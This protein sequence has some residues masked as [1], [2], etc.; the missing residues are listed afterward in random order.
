MEKFMLLKYFNL[1]VTVRR[2]RKGKG[3]KSRLVGFLDF[4]IN[5]EMDQ[6]IYLKSLLT[7]NGY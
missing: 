4:R 3:K 7:L 1:E 6:I 5:T 2:R